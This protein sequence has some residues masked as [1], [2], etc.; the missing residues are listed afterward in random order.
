MLADTTWYRHHEAELPSTPAPILPLK[1]LRGTTASL[2]S[3]HCIGNYGHFILDCLSRIHLLESAGY[4]LSDFDHILMPRPPS[5][6]ALA[7]AEKAGIP[8]SK[9]VWC[10]DNFLYQTD[11]LFATTFP[12]LRRS[13]PSWLPD[14]LKKLIPQTSRS[15]TV[16]VYIP[17][18]SRT[19]NIV[20]DAE[21]QQIA[22]SF[23]YKIFSPANQVDANLELSCASHVISA[24]G[25][26]LTDI[27]FCNPDAKVLEL[28]PS[29][30]SC[31]YYY[32]ISLAGGLDYYILFG[33]SLGCREKGSWG[34]SV[35][36]FV[37]DTSDFTNAILAL[38]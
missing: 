3:D 22:L 29:D 17:R 38:E 32:S 11:D 8:L 34:P 24:S 15:E 26:A 18:D 31:P 21:L 19:R 5:K 35:Y 27:I 12:G 2:C 28:M 13:Y 9:A 16:K 23:G 10:N 14:Y 36:D 30:H 20:N 4:K 33:K 6:N 7:L 1:R 37:I 25:A